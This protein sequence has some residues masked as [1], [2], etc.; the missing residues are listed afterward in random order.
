M[1]RIIIDADPGT[2]DV[3]AILLAGN[4]EKI[5]IEGITTVSGNCSLENATQNTFKALDLIAKKEVPVYKGMN[6]ALKTKHQD[7][8]DVFGNNGM[9]GVTY[10]PINVEIQKQNAI[11][12]LI[13]KVNNNPNQITIVAIGPLTNIA[14]AINKSPK[15]VKNVNKLIIMGGSAGKGN[16]TPHAE[17]NFYKDPEAANI[18]FSANFKE[19]IMFGWDVTTQLPLNKKY[20]TLLKDI[21]NDISNFLFDITRSAADFDRKNGYE[22]AILSDPLTIAYLIEDSMVKL[23]PAKVNIELSGDKIGKSNV[24]FTENSNCKVA[25]D[26]DNH[27]FYKLLFKSIFNTDIK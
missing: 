22:G 2:D 8:T 1:E 20:E 10:D 23:K 15:F 14:S 5:R 13:E 18:V 9:G 12:Y 16:I 6:K 7:A 17:F 27:K 25:Y 26:V 24:E 11:D 3:F 21:N 19:I 4:S